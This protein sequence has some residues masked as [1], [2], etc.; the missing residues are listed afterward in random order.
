MDFG[1][2]VNKSIPHSRKRFCFF[3]IISDTLASVEVPREVE[4]E[5][6]AIF[7]SAIRDFC[8]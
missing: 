6:K 8:L 1:A 3:Q 7:C 4:P 5:T 2:C